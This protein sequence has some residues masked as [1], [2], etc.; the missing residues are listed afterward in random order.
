V[1]AWLRGL[2]GRRQ[3]DQQRPMTTS[4]ETNEAVAI[5][6]RV[7]HSLDRQTNDRRHEVSSIRLEQMRIRRDIRD[8]ADFANVLNVPPVW[9]TVRR[10][11][12]HE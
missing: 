1:R 12:N 9:D 11:G 4:P 2:F 10:E 3:A 8:A 6:R 7:R 5:A